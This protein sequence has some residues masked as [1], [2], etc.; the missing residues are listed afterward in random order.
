M[1]LWTYGKLI[2]LRRAGNEL[3]DLP[4]DRWFTGKA[5]VLLAR[6][7]FNGARGKVELSK[8]RNRSHRPVPRVH[9]TAEVQL[10]EAQWLQPWGALHH[11]D[12]WRGLQI[13]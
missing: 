12:W 1:L 11:G 7:Q 3:I 4:S 10:P 13:L 6:T 8:V 9:T 2:A 5:R